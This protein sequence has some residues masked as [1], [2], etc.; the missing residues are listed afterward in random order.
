[1]SLHFL[2]ALYFHRT[3]SFYRPDIMLTLIRG[4]CDV[5]MSTFNGISPIGACIRIH[6]TERQHLQRKMILLLLKA[7]CRPTA[8]VSERPHIS[9]G[10]KLE[11]WNSLYS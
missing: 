4:G 8:S 6:S 7:G 5:N 2:E 3:L 10:E 9:V 11:F 1:M